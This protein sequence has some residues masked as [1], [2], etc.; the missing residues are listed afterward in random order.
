MIRT[1]ICPGSFDP[2]TMG[3]LDIISRACKIFDRIIVAVPVNP[4]KHFSFSVEERM[5]LLQRVCD[6]AGLANVEIDRVTGLLADYAMEKGAMVVVK[7]LRAVSDF[8]YEFQQALANKKLNPR[9]ETMFLPTSSD[10]MFLSSSVVKQIAGFGGDISHF[11]PDCILHTI[12][13]R[14]CKQG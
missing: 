2:V 6:G 5:E 3:H 14:L 4:Q 1:A 13:E 9:L 11:V 8:E 12:Q 7:G 10:N